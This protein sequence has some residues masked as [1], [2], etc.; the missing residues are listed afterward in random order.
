VSDQIPIRPAITNYHIVDPTTDLPICGYDPRPVL[1]FA[2]PARYVSPEVAHSLN[3]CSR[4]RELAD[5]AHGG[6]Q[7][8]LFA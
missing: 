2:G 4:C 3:L 1:N 7:E 6:R 8:E 5:A